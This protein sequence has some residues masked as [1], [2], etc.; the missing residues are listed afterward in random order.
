MIRRPP[1]STRTDTLFPY[2]TLFRS[3]TAM[4]EG[5]IHA[6]D[7]AV[8]RFAAR[9]A[10]A[11]V[12]GTHLAPSPWPPNRPGRWWRRRTGAQDPGAWQLH[13]ARSVRVAADGPAG[14]VRIAGAVA[15]GAGCGA[16]AWARATCV[17]AVGIGR[18]SRREKV[19]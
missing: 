4:R 7:H 5:E 3:Q 2:T 19:W 8:V 13:R 10:A 6:A 17:R 1:R 16:V 11:G 9:R 12:A 14:A 18:A 15:V